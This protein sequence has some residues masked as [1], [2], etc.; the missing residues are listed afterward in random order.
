[1]SH[2]EAERE[3]LRKEQEAAQARQSS[4]KSGGTRHKHKGPH[5]IPPMPSHQPPA[6]P[7][8]VS[9]SDEA[10][11]TIAMASKEVKKTSKSGTAEFQVPDRTLKTQA[12]N[13]GRNGQHG[14]ILPI[15]EEAG[16]GSRDDSGA[17][18]GLYVTAPTRAAPAV[19]GQE[20]RNSA[21]TRGSLDK[22]LPPLP[23]QK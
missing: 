9:T 12:V 10:K 11:D 5:A 16:E 2:E 22:D 21:S 17:R 18:K 6:P 1:M 14:S 3:A 23:P 7:G 19:P 15:V 20:Q 4:E 8:D 13:D